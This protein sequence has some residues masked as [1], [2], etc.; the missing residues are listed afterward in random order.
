MTQI[1]EAQIES[2]KHENRQLRLVIT[3]K[4]ATAASSKKTITLVKPRCKPELDCESFMLQPL[5]VVS[6]DESTNQSAATAS[7]PRAD[8]VAS[9][10]MNTPQKLGA[11]PV[12]LATPPDRVDASTLHDDFDT[13]AKMEFEQDDAS[14]DLLRQFNESIFN[15]IDDLIDPASRSS[16]SSELGRSF[17]LNGGFNDDL[18]EQAAAAAA[19]TTGRS[20]NGWCRRQLSSLYHAR[21]SIPSFTYQYVACKIAAMK[22]TGARA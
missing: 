5:S 9:S 16:F 14:A 12:A 11:E 21:C 10:M 7:S 13:S 20:V 2:A 8:S 4:G 3:G 1:L 22:A 18:G 6:V 17:F 15:G 19:P